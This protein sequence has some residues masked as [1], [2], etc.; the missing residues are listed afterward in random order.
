[1]QIQTRTKFQRF[2]TRFELKL[3]QLQICPADRALCVK[4][5][6]SKIRKCNT[7]NQDLMLWRNSLRPV[8]RNCRKIALSLINAESKLLP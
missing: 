7:A 5:N 1:M 2:V 4:A 6:Q 3:Q 8:L